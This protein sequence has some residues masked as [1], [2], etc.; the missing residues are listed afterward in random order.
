MTDPELDF[1]I[2]PRQVVGA[3]FRLEFEQIVL[4]KFAVQSGWAREAGAYTAISLT[5]NIHSLL[6][7]PG[8]P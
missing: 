3:C 1:V 4:S 5:W 7:M 8:A 2:I 6:G